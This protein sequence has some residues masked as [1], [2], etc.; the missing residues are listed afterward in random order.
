M[1]VKTAFLNGEIQEEVYVLQPE[2]YEKKGQER[3]VCKLLK[4]L[5]GLK[6]APRAWREG[7][8]FLIVGFY[9]DDLLITGS[10]HGNVKKFKDQ[11]RSEFDMSDLGK[12]AYYLGIELSKDV[13]GKAVD[14]TIY[15]SLVGGLRYLVHTRSDISYAVGMVSHFME[16][17]TE[18]HLSAVK[19]I[20]RY[21]ADSDSGGNVDD[22]KSTSGM[23][24]YL[25][26]SLITECVETGKIIVRYIG[27]GEQRADILTK[28]LSTA[29]FEKMREL[30]GRSSDIVAYKVACIG[31]KSA[32]ED[33]TKLESGTPGRVVL[34]SATLLNEILEITSKFMT[35]PD[36]ILVKLDE[37]A[38]EASSPRLC[39]RN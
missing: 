21:V 29:R 38:L 3:K 5:Y 19:R 10:S 37:L 11:M 26:E 39:N 14:S 36:R 4:T 16:R 31:G 28:D 17:P 32:G 20:L 2:G 25:S 27:T 34:N 8:E 7:N 35:D 22:R 18:Q 6:Q 23:A 1:D 9:V 24:F 15:K 12:L 30:I 33:I 13:T